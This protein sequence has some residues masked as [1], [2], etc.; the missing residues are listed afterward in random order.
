MR[1]RSTS[2]CVS[3]GPRVPMPPP[4]PR[5]VR[6]HARETRQHVLELRQLHLEP[7]L[8]RARAAGEDVEDELA[9]VDDPDASG[10]PRDSGSARARGR[11]RR[12]GVSPSARPR[13]GR[14]SRRSSPCSGTWRS[15][16]S[17]G[18]GAP[19]PGPGPPPSP[20][21]GEAR[22]ALSPWSTRDVERPA[23]IARSR[24]RRRG[25]TGLKRLLLCTGSEGTSGRRWGDLQVVRHRRQVLE[26]SRPAGR[27][28]RPRSGSRSHVTDSR[29]PA[30]R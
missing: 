17:R 27:R 13:E 26:S 3:P 21:G 16:R 2:S 8:A 29:G 23:R 25:A 28:P 15:A 9:P 12:R 5:E 1:R 19:R 20:R 14:G 18:A 11:R 10:P 24:P 30:P 4:Q 7:G 6:P 22:S